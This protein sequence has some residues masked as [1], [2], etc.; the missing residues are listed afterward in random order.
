MNQ[1][2]TDQDI[3]EITRAIQELSFYHK[4]TGEAIS[5]LEKDLN[6]L[7]THK[8]IKITKTL[9]E[10]KV[11][12]EDCRSLI[13]R[14]VRIVNPGKGEGNFGHIKSVGDL[15]ITVSV[16]GGLER[17]RIAKNLRLQH[18]ESS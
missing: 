4:K 12:L 18:H 9:R 15:Y 17:R 7:R 10:S 14:N 2:T 11:T 8:D 6:R 13:G 1:G 16:Q 3:K 5:R